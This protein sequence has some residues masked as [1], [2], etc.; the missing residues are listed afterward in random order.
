M[1]SRIKDLNNL[2]PWIQ[3]SGLFQP[4]SNVTSQ[5]TQHWCTL[6]AP[7][8]ESHRSALECRIERERELVCGFNTPSGLRQEDKITLGKFTRSKVNLTCNLVASEYNIVAQW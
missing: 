3:Y 1:W 7:V 6:L 8:L 5:I 2:G 4:L